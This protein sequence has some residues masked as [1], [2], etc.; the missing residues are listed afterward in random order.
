MIS[1]YDIENSWYNSPI[2]SP[3]SLISRHLCCKLVLVWGLQQL[4]MLPLQLETSLSQVQ[5]EAPHW[6]W[7][8]SPSLPKTA[9][10]GHLVI[11]SFS[12]VHSQSVRSHHQGSQESWQG[13]LS[14]SESV[15]GGSLSSIMA[16]IMQAWARARHCT[17]NNNYDTTPLC[18]CNYLI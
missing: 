13:T 2:I 3:V 5:V 17:S 9:K 1:A 18:H 4:F 16:V 8:C 7:A 14:H 6:Q 10:V 12:Q 15:T 11:A